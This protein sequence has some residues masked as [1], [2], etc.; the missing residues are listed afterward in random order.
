MSG[1][2]FYWVDL[3]D[4]DLQGIDLS[5]ADMI[6]ANLIGARGAGAKL[7]Y[8]DLRGAFLCNPDG[9][10]L[11]DT[12]ADLKGADLTGANLYKVDLSGVN[13]ENAVLR[14]ANLEAANLTGTCLRGANLRGA[15]LGNA[16]MVK[17]DL[18]EAD[19][20]GCSVYGISA[21]DN[22]LDAIH[23]GDLRI[24]SL[25]DIPI[26]VDGLE[27]AQVLYLM[28]KNRNLS[29]IIDAAAKKLVLI[30]GRFTE[31]RKLILDT[32]RDEIRL[33]NYIPVVY[34]FEKPRSRDHTETVSALAHFARFIIVDLTDARSVPQELSVIVPNLPSV[35]IQ[36]II[37]K[38]DDEY[39]MFEHWKRYPS[40]LD[41][42][43]YQD[44]DDLLI[45]LK[46]SII[47]T[48]EQQANKIAPL[49]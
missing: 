24:S 25:D 10:V 41:V 48:A 33:R 28:L 19:I 38:D 30:L 46:M 37:Q 6:R 27:A 22:Q 7:A 32:L 29:K 18:R 17:A 42:Y 21:W 20:Q 47:D 4:A 49:N 36:P 44:L 26:T 9:N 13:L 45:H 12:A 8:A 40:V 35:A 31:G 14:Q 39:G 5:Y 2:R 16:I 3:Y 23:Q 1:V 34:D 15:N 11:D 43:H